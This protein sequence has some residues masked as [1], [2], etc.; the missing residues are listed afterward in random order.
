MRVLPAIVA[1][2]VLAA[3]ASMG[4]PEGGPRDETAPVYVRSNPRP[5]ELNVNRNK[6]EIYFDENVQLEDPSNK[7]VVSPA[8]K[9]QAVATANGR[10]VTVELRDTLLPETTYTIDFAD[11]IADLNEKNILDGFALDFSTG[12]VID[13]LRIS[14]MVLEARNLEPAQGMLV[15]VYSNTADSAIWSEKLERITKTNQLGQFT[16]RNLKPGSYRIYALNDVNHDYRWDRSEDVAFYDVTITPTSEAVTVTDTLAGW[17]GRDSL[18]SRGATRYLPNDILLTWFNEGFRAQYLADNKRTERNMIK[19]TLGAPTDTL[20]RLRAINGPMA[21]RSIEEW[22]VLEATTGLDTLSYWITDS[23]VIKQ[24]SLLLEATYQKLDSLDRLVWTTDTLRMFSRPVKAEKPKKK[25]KEEEADS[26]APMKFFN[27][28]PGASAS[29]ELN[30][31]LLFTADAPI[32]R[33]DTSAI[34]LEMMVDT[35]WRE[36]EAPRLLEQPRYSRMR[37]ETTAGWQPGARYRL[38]ID[39]ASVHSIYGLFN[40]R[41]V[42]EFTVKTEEDYSALIFN[43]TGLDGRGAMAELLNGDKPV[44]AVPVAD[45]RAEFTFVAPGTYYA[46][47]YIDG[48]RNGKWDT[49]NLKEHVQPEEVYYYPKKINL[50]K[51]W[52]IEQTWNIYETALDQQKPADI[53]ANKPK[54]RQGEERETEEEEE[55]DDPYTDPYFRYDGYN[56]MQR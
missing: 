52:D 44:M 1:A 48:N 53:K 41:I 46:R 37:V 38:T 23:A 9:N 36:I 40:K 32:A 30:K 54:L 18:V 33:I 24:D 13:T 4:R 19:L 43:V 17:D 50:K 5:G 3:C 35:T 22:S 31:G 27:F 15:G 26:V 16:V 7:V 55:E 25:K 20:P 56:R 34:H 49:G 47:L 12:P 42:H 11:A 6:I 8:Q 28:Q 21:G 2:L 39:S 45:G 29:Q 51:N 10:K 14:G